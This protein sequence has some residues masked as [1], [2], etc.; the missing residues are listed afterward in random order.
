MLSTVFMINFVL[1]LLPYI[2]NFANIGAFVSGLLL[3][4]VLLF[5]PQVRQMSKNK[6]GL[7]EYDLKSSIKQKMK[8]NLQMPKQKMDKPVLRSVSLALFLIL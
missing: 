6:A 3:G 2:D 8:L 7:F 5:T 1:G 4:F